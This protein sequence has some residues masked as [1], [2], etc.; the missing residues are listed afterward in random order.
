MPFHFIHNF[1]VFF[2]GIIEWMRKKK[3][4]RNWSYAGASK[5]VSHRRKL[6]LQDAFWN[7][8]ETLITFDGTSIIYYQLVA[9]HLKK[10]KTFFFL[11]KLNRNFF[12]LLSP[13]HFSSYTL[14]CQINRIMAQDTTHHCAVIMLLWWRKNAN[15]LHAQRNY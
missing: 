14:E 5:I 13:E 9:S 1:V 3:S 15:I 4:Q 11:I 12:F 2:A 8:N 7:L 6:L 10:S